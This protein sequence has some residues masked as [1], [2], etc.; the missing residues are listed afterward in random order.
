MIDVSYRYSPK[1]LKGG[2][3]MM[4]PDTGI[5]TLVLP[6]PEHKPAPATKPAPLEHG[7]VIKPKAGKHGA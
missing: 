4:D 3:M 6:E 5:E 7:P 1:N 2:K